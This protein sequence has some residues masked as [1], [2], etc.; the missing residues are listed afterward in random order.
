MRFLGLWIILLHYSTSISAYDDTRKELGNLV[1]GQ[2]Y[3]FYSNLLDEPQKYTV[4]L[5]AGYTENPSQHYPVVYVLDGFE[6]QTQLAAT[7]MRI[8]Y[9]TGPFSAPEAVIIGLPSNNR[10]RDYTPIASNIDFNG[11]PQEWL[12]EAG[13]GQKYQAFLKNEFFDHIAANYRVNGHKIVIGHSFGG[14]LALS[15][16]LSGEPLFQSYLVVD[17][18]LWFGGEYLLNEVKKTESLPSGFAGNLYIATALYGDK[19]NR[20]QKT[21]ELFF[22]NLL[23]HRL[24]N[25][26]LKH[27][28][29]PEEN[30]SSLVLQAFHNGIRYIFEGYKPPAFDDIAQDPEILIQHY[31]AF[32]ERFGVTYPPEAW[33]VDASAG[34]ALDKEWN[35]NVFKLLNLNAKHYPKRILSWSNLA[36]VYTKI[37]D[38]AQAKAA[39]HRVLELDPDNVSAK[40][41]LLAI[42]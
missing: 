34:I 33:V 35:N 4:V 20:I 32:S 30:H 2:Q 8:N 9:E 27:E 19:D 40:E 16:L 12:S 14:L 22:S 11:K 29:F 15:N 31:E 3:E 41:Q 1:L 38:K 7:A 13:G 18:S 23:T 25:V 42:E 5:P 6:S 26:Y 10:N 28:V 36:D 37:G 39:L 17:P 24:N 21:G